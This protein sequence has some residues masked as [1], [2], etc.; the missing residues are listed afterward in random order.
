MVGHLYP[1]FLKQDFFV[2]CISGGER[3][4]EKITKAQ[5]KEK[6]GEEFIFVRSKNFAALFW[7]FLGILLEFEEMDS[8]FDCLHCHEEKHHTRSFF[9]F[10]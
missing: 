7:G 6:E 1:P 10:V 2:N 8:S 5:Q 9:W 4:G 3:I